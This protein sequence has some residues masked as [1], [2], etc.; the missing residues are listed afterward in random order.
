MMSD[1]LVERTVS[2][3]LLTIEAYVQSLPSL[4]DLWR[5]K[6]HLC[7]R[8][9][10]YF[11]F[12]P[13]VSFHKSSI[14]VFIYMLFLPGQHMAKAWDASKALFVQKSR[15]IEQKSTSKFFILLTFI[16]IRLCHTCSSVDILLFIYYYSVHSA[17]LK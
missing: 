4:C 6:W 16:V 11:G 17:Y 9:S 7:R 13:S 10:N 2:F 8:F 15:N 5:T 14:L 1:F 12:P 3:Q